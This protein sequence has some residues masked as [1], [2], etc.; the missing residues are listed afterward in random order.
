LTESVNPIV[1]STVKIIIFFFFPRLILLH[2]SIHTCRSAA[3]KIL[4]SFSLALILPHLPAIYVIANNGAT[5]AKGTNTMAN[6][7]TKTAAPATKAKAP[8]AP[9]AAPATKTAA[10]VA[11]PTAPTYIM[12]GWPAKAQGGG[13]VRAYCYQVAQGLLKANPAGFTKAQYASALAANAA[14]STCKQPSTGWGTSAK[15]NGAAHA[16]ANWFAH[17]KQGWLAP[18]PNSKA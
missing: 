10:P 8:V 15:P 1:S 9:T 17:T 5:Q 4:N 18:A 12:G 3:I 7:N 13:S 6:A 11:A 16:H 2:R 14:G